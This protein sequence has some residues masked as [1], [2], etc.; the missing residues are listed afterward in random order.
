MRRGEQGTAL[1][2]A[3]LLVALMA[4]V[5]VQLTDVTRFAVFR[6][7]QIDSRDQARWYARGA[8]E[9]AESVLARSVAQEREVTRPTALWRQGPHVFEIERGRISGTIRDGNNCF[10]INALHAQAGDDEDAASVQ[11]RQGRAGAMFTRLTDQIG[12]PRGAAERLKAQMIDWIDADTRPELG[13]AEDDVYARFDPPYRAANQPFQELEEM[14]ALPEM[15]PDLYRALSPWLCVRPDDAQ[16][17]LNVNTLEPGQAPLLSAAFEGRLSASDAEAV[18]FRRPPQGY[19]T[20]EAFWAEPLMARLEAGAEDQALVGVTT[21]WFEMEVDVR[22]DDTRF[23]LS[24]L[25]ELQDTGR[26]ARHG[27]RFGAF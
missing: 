6:T 2:A 3:L 26:I 27:E 15:T 12:L 4:A 8:R 7:A 10:N 1:I 16:P 17:P 14:L 11:A 23:T 22:V 13:G 9:F 20:I 25:A 5:A 19:D 21:R 18:L 24:Q